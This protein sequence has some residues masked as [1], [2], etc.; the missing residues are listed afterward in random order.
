[1]KKLLVLLLAAV[2]V[3]ALTACG[4]QA[5]PAPAAETPSAEPAAAEPTAAEDITL[6]VVICQYGPGTQEWFLGK[7][8]NGTSFVDKFETENPGVKLH[9]EVIPRDDI[10]QVVETRIA[11]NNAPDI[12]NIDTFSE[13]VSDGLLMPVK[14]YCPEDLYNDFFPAF[15]AESVIDGTVWALPDLV[16]ARALFCNVDLL[17]GAGVEVPT[18]WA[19]L[20]DACQA[21]LDYYDGDVYPW[22]IDM[23]TEED[24]FCFACCAWGNGGGFT[25]GDG[26]WALNRAENVEAVEFTIGLVDKFFSNATPAT[27]TIFDLQDMFADGK[28][29]MLLTTHRLPAYISEKGGSINMTAAG[30]PANE[31]KLGS[32]VGD[33]ERIMVF[34]GG[35]APDQAARSEAIGKFLKFFYDPEN[36]VGRVGTEGFLPAVNSAVEALA[37]S[38]PSFGI[39]SDILGS[40]RFYPADKAEWPAVRQG[41]TAVEQ[42]ALIGGDI[43]AG[44]DALQAEVTG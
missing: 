25:D 19:E 31:G 11:N 22:G 42:L 24:P 26:S 23:T 30:I 5:A 10:H 8:M 35:S 1:M 36:Y 14:D 40:C 28:L 12:L 29:A 15:I 34:R 21:I 18:T 32:S 6:D 20:E 3:F 39:W 7:G 43:R 27:E 16:S 2:M 33:M 17:K 13:F 44:L 38:D 41:I 4:Q 37:V 9:L